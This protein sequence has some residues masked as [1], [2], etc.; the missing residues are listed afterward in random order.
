MFL[1]LPGIAPTFHAHFTAA[2]RL[3]REAA[4]C[5]REFVKCISSLCLR[6][7]AHAESRGGS[8]ASNAAATVQ[9]LGLAMRDLD[10]LSSD[11]VPTT[12]V[13]RATYEDA[14]LCQPLNTIIHNVKANGHGKWCDGAEAGIER[15][16]GRTMRFGT[17]ERENHQ[18]DVFAHEEAHADI[19]VVVYF[20]YLRCV[21]KVS[22]DCEGSRR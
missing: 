8:S 1:F 4:L 2:H 10:A 13:E 3:V 6:Q 17:A 14:S 9:L 19:G 22:V 11:Y 20:R 5:I 12:L 15:V 7:L 16:P 18:S 21:D